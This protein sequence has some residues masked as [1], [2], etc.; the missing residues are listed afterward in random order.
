VPLLLVR[1]T[2]SPVVSWVVSLLG[3][4]LAHAH[5]SWEGGLATT[6]AGILLT[7]YYLRHGSLLRVMIAHAVIDIIASFSFARRSQTE[8]FR[9]KHRD[10]LSPPPE[11]TAA[12]LSHVGRFR[13]TDVSVHRNGESLVKWCMV[14]PIHDDRQPHTIAAISTPS[15]GSEP[16]GFRLARRDNFSIA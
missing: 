11:E 1:A 15:I 7:V 16:S 3:F 4:G 12:G 8:S 10:G 6:A 5:D 9:V 13:L 14:A 2:G